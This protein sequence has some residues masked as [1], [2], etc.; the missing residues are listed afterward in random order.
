[1]NYDFVLTTCPFCGCGC[2]FY[3]QVLDG[4]LTGITPCKSDE[5]SQGKLCI[6]GR[7]A[8]EF[9]NHKDRLTT[10]LIKRNGQFEPATWDEALDIICSSLSRIKQDFGP[11]SIGFLSS[12]KCT[13]EE[14]F[15]LMK[16]ARAVIGTN[17]IDH[18]A[19]LCHASTVLGLVSSFGSGAMT[20]SIPE[21]EWA[22]C[23]FVIGS[24]TIEQ[25]PLIGSRILKAKEN[26]AKLIVVDPRRTPLVDFADVYLQLKPGSDI[27]LLNGMMH[28]IIS[29]G[30]ADTD[31]ISSRTEGFEDL[32]AKVMEYPPER[33]C[34]ITG[35]EPA[36]LEAAA[37]I[38]GEAERGMLI[39]CMGITQHTCGTDNVRSCAN[40]AMLT[41][42]IG[43]ESTGVNPLR[44]QNNVQGAC[45][46][47]AL[48]DL[49][50]GYQSV[51][52]EKARNSFEGAW[53]TRLPTSPGLTVTE[54][55]DAADQG[56]LKAMYVVGENPSLS[57]PDID[58]VRKSL[59]SLDFLVVQDIFLSETAQLA[60]V[61]LPACSFAEREG[62]FT[63]TDRRVQRIRKAIDPVEDSRPDWLI[64]TQLA[65]RIG[66]K[67]FDYHSPEDIMAEIARLTPIYAG[68]SY[69]RLDDGKVLAWP[70][71][72]KEHPG[73]KLLHSEIFT[74]GKGR[75]F[76]V[77]YRE[78]AEL[79]DE[80]FP[81]ILTTGRVLFQYHTG[82]MSRRIAALEREASTGFVEINP[83]DAEVLSVNHGEKVK[84]KSRRGEI[85]IEAFI[86]DRV[87]R[88]VTFIPFHF[89]ECPANKLT[90]RSLDPEAKIPEFKVCAVQVYKGE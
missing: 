83:E 51:Q 25:H 20:N 82:T 86:T 68:I 63:A 71:P 27:A 4:E 19:R 17:N 73:T 65:Q 75:F 18:C 39:Y 14:N 80:E 46:M 88:G 36:D 70:C 1:M 50:S 37:R 33:V 55:I 35:I 62:T 48:P 60:H 64:I 3:L 79:P 16:F 26:G 11:D 72:T 31:F 57:D 8:F 34:Q 45:D 54:M 40:L 52:D 28:F 78:P 7:N 85:E 58:H 84:V 2:Q 69:E 5:V 47:G 77:D 41:G 89:A 12:A 87:P 9:V 90:T 38:Y 66:A 44:G 43:K 22:D 49:Y 59:S 13:N 56:A 21:V 53:E 30:L 74:R 81:F 6:K 61:V 29:L 24:N 23:F 10:P 42:N 67:G 15:L 32:K 76:P